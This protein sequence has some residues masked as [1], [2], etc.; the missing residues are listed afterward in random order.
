DLPGFGPRIRGRIM[1]DSAA[2]ARP[3]KGDRDESV[4]LPLLLT[5]AERS[6]LEK[7]TGGLSLEFLAGGY[8]FNAPED[9]KRLTA[10]IILLA[11]YDRP[12]SEV[13][14]KVRRAGLPFSRDS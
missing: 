10:H 3:E 11:D 1:S 4:E 14:E 2:G 6:E 9:R 7:L 13:W 5:A 12:P 8:R